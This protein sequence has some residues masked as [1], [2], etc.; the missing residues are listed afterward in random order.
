MP[1]PRGHRLGE[2]APGDDVAGA[3]STAR[4]GGWRRVGPTQPVLKCRSE[5]GVPCPTPIQI[6]RRRAP[7]SAAGNCIGRP[8]QISFSKPLL[9]CASRNWRRGTSRNKVLRKKNC[10]RIA[11]ATTTCRPTFLTRHSLADI[12]PTSMG[13]NSVPNRVHGMCGISRLTGPESDLWKRSA[14]LA[15]HLRVGDR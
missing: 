10:S 8:T 1:P 5:W 15:P 9:K 6:V 3:S 4:H 12:R 7:I 2:K 13:A 14:T 11:R